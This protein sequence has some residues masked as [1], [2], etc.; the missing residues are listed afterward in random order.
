MRLRVVLFACVLGAGNLCFAESHTSV[1]RT[2]NSDL[3]D[4]LRDKSELVLSDH[5]KALAKQWMLE[6][7]DWVKYKQIM[8]GPRGIWSPGL[9]PLTALGVSENDPKERQRY[10][11][12]WMKMEIRRNELE[13]AFEVERQKAAS[14]ILGNQLAVNNKPWIKEWENKQVEVTHQVV[15]FMEASCKEKCKPMFQ[16]LFKSIGD[17]TKLDIYFKQGA[18]SEDIGQWAS[19]MDIDPTLVRSRK[20]TL[21]FDEGVS[22][23]LKVSM[24]SLPQVRV[25]NLKT[26]DVTESNL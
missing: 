9:D 20:V 10:A 13:L 23:S 16:D 25:V 18:G 4:S 3:S 22:A 6:E 24:D 7:S 2:V 5:E 11:E 17:N 26:G 14:R 12:L 1:T 21:N 8:S 15:L 19:F